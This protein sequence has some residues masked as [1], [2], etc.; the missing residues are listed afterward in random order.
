MDV[1]AL[2]L[3]LKEEGASAVRAA[4]D[5][6]GRSAKVVSKELNALDKSSSQLGNTLKGL[7]AGITAG[8]IF[9]KFAD[10]TAN[11]QFAQVA[12]AATLQSTGRS[13][14]I[15]LRQLNDYASAIQQTTVFSD[16][17]VSSA[18]AILLRF[19]KISDEAFPQATKA[20]VDL[21]QALTIDL[22][23]AAAMVGRAL[24]AP[25]QASRI[26]K[27]AQIVLSDAQLELIKN[28]TASGRTAE[29]QAIIFAEFARVSEDAAVKARGTLG[30]A[31]KAL[32]N[33]FGELF[34]MSNTGSSVFTMLIN[35]LTDF[36]AKHKEAIQ[37]F[38]GNYMPK[39]IGLIAAAAT[40]WLGYQTAIKAAFLWTAAISAAQ[41]L[42]ALLSL[43]KT[44]RSLA[45]AAALVSMATG[46]WV[47]LI[48]TVMAVAG[49]MAAWHFATK[50]LEESA[51]Q[52]AAELEKMINGGTT[53]KPP[54]EGI[55]TTTKAVE[56]QVAALMKL[57]EITPITR[58][59]LGVLASEEQRLKNALAAGNLSYAKRL[60]LTTRLRDVE[61]ARAGARL[62]LTR[63]ELLNAEMTQPGATFT[64][65]RTVRMRQGALGAEATLPPNA[66]FIKA[67]QADAK[68]VQAQTSGLVDQARS[69][70]YTELETLSMEM[71][72]RIRETFV[73][74]IAGGIEAAVATGSIGEGFKAL[75]ASL[76]SG[77]GSML[78]Q[79]GKQ[80]IASSKLIIGF[81]ES[82]KA[83]N[84]PGAL[85]V[86]IAMVALGAALRGAA[87][88]AF[89]GPRGN[90]MGGGV[91]GGM[92]GTFGGGRI[93]LPTMTFG[94]TMAGAA[95]GV[96]AVAPMNVTIIGPNDPTA[97]RAMQEL[98]TKAQRRG[99]V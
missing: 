68:K 54:S 60:E 11:A 3:R 71:S 37:Q 66:P 25:E 29:A 24:Q 75:G 77:L 35:K 43:V 83:L 32:A 89:G 84:G 65:G 94:P 6:L 47:K 34:E 21:A 70:L 40:A 39:A 69:T 9:K 10:E 82:I 4:T 17:A 1:F 95:A 50:K 91:G 38:I 13:A 92:G 36:F 90:G 26:L 74:G 42:G 51:K 48:A 56:D 97:Q 22:S 96:N 88:A 23:Q 46:G 81:M 19:G 86:G 63:E 45:D 28:L 80:A 44:V 72:N 57:A 7:A 62:R 30:G 93:T 87:Q 2:T 64:P 78:I 15:S 49:G 98:M 41:T 8:A 67:L 58:V 53:G 27:S 59:E 52:A 61:Q 16:E 99:S 33:N 31:L 14:S 55:D 73:D 12:L 20:A 5:A 18:Q 76:L 85:A 79:F